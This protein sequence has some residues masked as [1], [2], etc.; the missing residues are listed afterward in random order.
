MIGLLLNALGAAL[1]LPL[2]YLW[3]PL[4]RVALPSSLF[5]SARLHLGPDLYMATIKLLVA[6]LVLQCVIALARAWRT[7][8]GLRPAIV[9]TA[10][11]LA[12][13]RWGLIAGLAF[14][15]LRAVQLALT[16]ELAGLLIVLHYL[17][18]LT[19]WV[20]SWPWQA[21]WT[22]PLNAT[23]AA[24][25]VLAFAIALHLLVWVRVS[26]PPI[27]DGFTGYIKGGADQAA[28]L[29]IMES[30]VQ[31]GDVDLADNQFPA[32]VYDRELNATTAH[33]GGVEFHNRDVNWD[34]PD[35]RHIVLRDQWDAGLLSNHRCGTALALAPAY[36]LGGWLAPGAQRAMVGLWIIFLLAAGLRE[37]T[38]LAC[39]NAVPA[40]AALAMGTL[41]AATIPVVC[42]SQAVY[43]EPLMFFIV[44]RMARLTWD[45][46][47]SMAAHLEAGLWM[48]F[49]PWLQDK[50][51]L[52]VLPFF[53]ARLWLQ[54][55]AW[56]QA[57]PMF[58]APLVSLLL[59]LSRNHQVYGQWLPKNNYG[60]FVGW[61]EALRAGLPGNWLDWGYGLLILVPALI[62]APAGFVAAWRAGRGHAPA[63]ATILAA[64]GTVL[65]GWLLM[66]FWWAW[67]GVA[68]PPNRFMLPVYPLLLWAT[69]VASR[70]LCAAGSRLIPVLWGL[71]ALFGLEAMNPDL[72][73]T[74]G[75]PAEWF[76]RLTCW[77]ALKARYIQQTREQI[78]FTPG[79]GLVL[80]MA[81]VLVAAWW[82]WRVIVARDGLAA[83]RGKWAWV[84]AAAVAATVIQLMPDPRPTA[85]VGDVVCEIGVLRQPELIPRAT[86]CEVRAGLQLF[87]GTEH[88]GLAMGVHYYDAD[89]VRLGQADF[90][91]E[92]Y[93]RDWLAM[94]KVN[95][96][97]YVRTGVIDI[98]RPLRPP[99][100]TAIVAMELYNARTRV[101]YPNLMPGASHRLTQP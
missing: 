21:P 30:L 73:Y 49:A 38:L 82:T 22:K 59:F 48:A 41:G 24:N 57:G 39:R 68:C 90:D 74:F 29:A 3:Q 15:D 66:G 9:D 44:A 28:Y 37:I 7:G 17:G 85:D 67:F 61:S 42:Y 80:A 45:N 20:R 98:C 52:W 58:I 81:A 92:T 19:A 94:N 69:M 63:R 65:V 56:R 8:Q 50:Y 86:G 47:G 25:G 11:W 36:A 55:R 60:A 54:R 12:P 13:F 96:T 35:A 76:T 2:A 101:S 26:L 34:A 88:A 18:R 16:A 46:R 77:T 6:A 87:S 95:A 31:D 75:H 27:R 1:L 40:G 62:L 53:A 89:S 33:A 83:R 93:T 72:W 14:V 70:P 97:R 64:V 84:I 4:A 71:S 99:A 32:G 91:L 43:P 100:G 78:A 5:Y 51:G 23:T 79:R 10:R